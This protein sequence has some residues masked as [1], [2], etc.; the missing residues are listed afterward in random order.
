[1]NT[2]MVNSYLSQ[3]LAGTEDDTGSTDGGANED[4]G[5]DREAW[6]GAAARNGSCPS[7]IDSR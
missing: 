3:N 6:S 5:V 1:M 4:S 2:L 7:V